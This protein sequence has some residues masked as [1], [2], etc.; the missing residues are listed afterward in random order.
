MALASSKTLYEH[1]VNLLC[2]ESRVDDHCAIRC[3]A[4]SFEPCV[5]IGAT[6]PYDPVRMPSQI[7]P[8]IGTAYLVFVISL[9]HRPQAAN[10]MV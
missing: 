3:D 4:A 9:T 2:E 7:D 10:S 6:D 1:T 5:K 8:Q